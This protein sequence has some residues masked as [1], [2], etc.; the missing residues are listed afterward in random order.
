MFGSNSKILNSIKEY[1]QAYKSNIIPDL[2]KFKPY[3]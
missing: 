1:K 3:G 2:E